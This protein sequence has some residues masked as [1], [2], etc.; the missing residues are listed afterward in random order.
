MENNVSIW[1]CL[2]KAGKG[3]SG[4]STLPLEFLSFEQIWR[5]PFGEVTHSFQIEASKHRPVGC[6]FLPTGGSLS[7]P[8][9][10]CI[11]HPG[12]KSV[13]GVL[14][15]GAVFPELGPSMGTHTHR[16]RKTH[17]NTSQFC[18]RALV[19][20]SVRSFLGTYRHSSVCEA[21]YPT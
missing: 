4:T 19:I 3:Q 12:G 2:C 6:L 13:L 9:V 15:S 14:F 1:E 7:P 21:E 20:L 10:K 5:S 17:S 16:G 8:L 18:K 11:S